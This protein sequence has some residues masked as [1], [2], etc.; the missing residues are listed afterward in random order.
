MQQDTACLESLQQK[1][2]EQL[3]AMEA[4]AEQRQASAEQNIVGQVT[5]RMGE[6]DENVH[7]ECVKVYRNVQAVVVEESGKQSEALTDI[8][9]KVG[10]VKGKLGAILG[11]SITALVLS[12]GSVVMLVLELLNI[13]LF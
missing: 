13:K 3:T 6:F 8:S 1:I 7:R 2:S 5:E 11:I 9:A 12:L 10:S 4:A